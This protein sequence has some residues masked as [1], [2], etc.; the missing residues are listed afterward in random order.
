MTTS[1]PSPD[2]ATQ[3]LLPGQAAAPEG[4]A[5]TFMMYL[6][7]HGYRRDLDDFVAAVP[8]TPSADRATWRALADRWT[9]FGVALHHHHTA[10]D[11]HLWPA[12]LG[13]ADAPETA[14]L[15]A[16]EAE[17]GEIDPLLSSCADGFAR[18]S[19][20]GDDSVRAVL[21]E[22]L[23]VTRD[24]LAGHLAHEEIDAMVLVQKY[25]DDDGWSALEKKFGEDMGFTDLF[26]MI[27]WLLKGLSADDRVSVMARVPAPMRVI[28]WLSE[29]FFAR[30]ERR[31]FFYDVR[32]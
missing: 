30:A 7:H 9:A 16:M 31:A 21:G 25:F 15:D 5:D 32:R 19:D 8:H 10:E 3:L 23:V 20:G 26:W 22:V 18:M 17:H 29:P 12:L 14:I 11:A 6:M 13:C 24:R 1:I 2:S 4:P 28:A 27:P